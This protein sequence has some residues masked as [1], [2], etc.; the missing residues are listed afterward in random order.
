MIKVQVMYQ[1]N[2]SKYAKCNGTSDNLSKI[3]RKN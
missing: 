2:V 1:K 3:N